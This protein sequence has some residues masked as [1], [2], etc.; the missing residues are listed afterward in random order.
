MRRYI[1]TLAGGTA[2]VALSIACGDV[3][4][5]AGLQ[6]LG[7][8]GTENAGADSGDAGSNG[9]GAGNNSGGSNG[10]GGEMSACTAESVPLK[11]IERLTF[12]QISN[13]I[14]ALFGEELGQKIDVEFEIGTQ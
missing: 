10:A 6:V 9:A 3:H 5:G 14:R 8:A 11:R 13:T 12:N 2:A 1:S 7:P 4:R